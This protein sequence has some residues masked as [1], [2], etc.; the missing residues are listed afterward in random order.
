ALVCGEVSLSYAELDVRANRLA[1][2]LRARGA[3][4]ERLVAVALPRSA[5]LVV[6]IL[7]V[8]KSGAAYV[9]VDPEYPVAR[10][11]YLL[12]DARPVLTVTDTRTGQRLPADTGGRL[13]LDDPE[14]A[15]DVACR[16]ATDPRVAVDAGHPAY[17]I[18]T[19]GS[20]GRPKGVVATHGGLADLLADHQHRLFA[21]LLKDRQRLRVALTT[22]VSFDASWNQLMAP[23]AGHELHVLDH[24][25]WTDPEAFVSYVADRG[26]DYVEA[27]PSYLQD[28]VSQGL[29]SDAPHSPTLVGAGGEA[30]P[31]H[32]WERLRAADGTCCVNLYGPSECTVNS[33]TAVVASSPRP[34]IGRPVSNARLYVLDGALRPVPGGVAGELYIAGAGL[35]RGY[36]NRPGLTA[37]R[38]VADPFGADGARMY[39]TGDR[40][41]WN[42]EGDLEFL[43]RTDDQVKVRGFRIEPGEIEAVLAEHEDIARTAVIVRTDDEPRLVAYVVPA[44]GRDIQQDALRTRLRDRL[45][46]Y[47]V[48]SA[49]VVLDAL[50]LTPNGK[51]DRRALPAPGHRPTAPGRAPRSAVEHLLA[52]LFAE[53]L[54]TAEVGLEESFFDLGGHSLL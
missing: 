22:S 50:P 10:I 7:A 46:A 1:Q 18:H 34:V 27:T 8:L 4:P 36:L 32:L 54:G 16:P 40:V 15:A 35:A 29:L 33:V 49:I 44:A 39:R 30:V 26:L 12:D 51:L 24:A 53:V 3:G 6:A 43:G 19:S 42:P 47:M 2:E 13:V 5:D 23:F 20:T 48:P 17:V 38:F 52:G 25:T 41:R 37:G 21:P 9:P 45:P 11:A 31:Q 14:T 28:L